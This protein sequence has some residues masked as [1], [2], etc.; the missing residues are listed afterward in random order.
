MLSQ[1][2]EFCAVLVYSSLVT[3]LVYFVYLFVYLTY[4]GV[5]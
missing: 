4:S 5:A 1:S 3:S 2:I